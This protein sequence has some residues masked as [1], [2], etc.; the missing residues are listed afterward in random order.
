MRCITCIVLLAHVS[1][2]AASLLRGGSGEKVYMTSDLLKQL[3][4]PLMPKIIHQTWKDHDVPAKFQRWARSWQNCLPGWE[5]KMHDDEDNRNYFVKHFPD[6][7]NVYDS[8]DVPIKKVD[9]AR[10][11]YL[12]VDGGLYVDM[13]IECLQDPTSALHYAVGKNTDVTLA[14][15]AGIFNCRDKGQVSNAFMISSTPKGREF[16]TQVVY[17]LQRTPTWWYVLD[18]TGPLFFTRSFEAIMTR[19]AVMKRGLTKK[20]SG[21][22]SIWDFHT[23]PGTIKKLRTN[24][25][26]ISVLDDSLI[27]NVVWNDTSVKEGCLNRQWCQ[28]H[29][30]KALAVSHWSGSWMQSEAKVRKALSLV[31][32]SESTSNMTQHSAMVERAQESQKLRKGVLALIH[33]ETVPGIKEKCRC[34]TEAMTEQPSGICQKFLTAHLEDEISLQVPD[35]SSRGVM[36]SLQNLHMEMC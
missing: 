3:S 8:Y 17:R 36:R 5:Y 34:I 15:E 25:Y 13:D 18:A 9:A 33:S 21:Y 14:C 32:I 4:D 12:A 26:K 19:E 2:I 16:F 35:Y 10:Y 23:K 1:E 27:F 29:Y 24:D 22:T 30:P 11:A 7:L 31:R 20:D 6:L 28:K